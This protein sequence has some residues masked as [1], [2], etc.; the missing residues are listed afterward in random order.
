MSGYQV[1][2]A[3]PSGEPRRSPG[4]PAAYADDSSSLRTVERIR[5]R[6]ARPP[7]DWQKLLLWVAMI[8]GPWLV[9]GALVAL[10]IAWWP[11]P[12]PS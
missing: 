1:G 9:G 3:Y 5:M 2:Q 11:D 8:G 12:L 4:R 10:A 7:I 6:R